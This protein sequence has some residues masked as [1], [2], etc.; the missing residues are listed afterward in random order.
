MKAKKYN[1]NQILAI[2]NDLKANEAVIVATDTVMGLGAKASSKVAFD[3]LK[4]IKNRPENKPFPVMVSN[5]SQLEK[6]VDLAKRDKKLVEKWFP[7]PIT[8]IFNKKKNADIYTDV[9]TLAVR[10]PNDDLIL[11]IVETLDQPIYLTS[12]NKSGESTI[13]KASEALD[14]FENEVSSIMMSDAKGKRAST[15]ID[16]SGE[17]LTLIRKGKIKIEEVIESLEEE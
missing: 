10:M 7:G 8:F 6:I 11:K 1:E 9:K 14:I 17:D 12:A 5:I 13:L 15:I 2:C 16:A 4:K 3:K